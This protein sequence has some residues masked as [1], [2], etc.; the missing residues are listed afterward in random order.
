MRERTVFSNKWCWKNWISIFRRMKLDPYL[1]SYPQNNAKRIKNLNVRPK[2]VKPVEENI[3]K[4]LLDIIL[5]YV[6]FFWIWHK[7]HKQ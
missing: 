5:G 2:T 6:F 4:K 3:K 1:T 7:K